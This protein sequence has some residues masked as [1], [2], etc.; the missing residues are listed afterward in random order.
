L[1]KRNEELALLYEKIKIQKSTLKK[2]EIYY[3]E[4]VED[5]LNIQKQI[6]ELKRELIVSQNETACIPDLKREVYLLQKE[7]LEQ[8]QKAK[9]LID[10][11]EKPLNVHRWRKLEST[12]PETY[13]LIQKI[14]SLQKRLIAKT[15][16]VSEKDVLIQEKEKLYI[17][18]KNILAK[19][20]GPE[21]A[22]KLQ[23]YQQNLKERSKQLKDMVA[24]LK[25]YQSQVNAYRFENERLDKQIMEVK[26]AYFSQKRQQNMGVIKEMDD[27]DG[28]MGQQDD[29]G[30][31]M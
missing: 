19:Q 3:Q 30:Q 29:G 27:E 28:G 24:E 4:R 1:I 8:Q 10:E 25:N 2:G 18:L 14:Q 17:E 22:E 5:I 11:L 23:I 31:M 15:E 16:E 12:D 26:G 20:S 9:F 21:V 7:Y 6:S 13:E